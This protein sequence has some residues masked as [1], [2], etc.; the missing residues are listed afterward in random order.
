VFADNGDVLESVSKAEAMKIASRFMNQPE[1]QLSYLSE[2]REPDQWTL[3]ER[4]ILPAHKISA[5]HAA[6]TVLYLS[7]ES[8]EVD[9][10]ASRGSRAL[11]WVAAIPHWMYFAPLRQNGPLWRQVVMWTSGVAMVLAILGIILGFTQYSTRYAGVM[12]WHYVT[13][14]AFGVFSLTWV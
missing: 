3:E 14:V 4:S 9:L 13:G 1:T 7:H 10:V 8:A 2:I 5:S 12:R 6:A 11:A